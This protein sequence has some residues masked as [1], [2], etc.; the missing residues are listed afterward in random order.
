M[1]HSAEHCGEH[2]VH[3]NCGSTITLSLLTLSLPLYVCEVIW[4]RVCVSV[5]AYECR[6]G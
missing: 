5:C 6:A 1:K 2:V 4:P 3:N